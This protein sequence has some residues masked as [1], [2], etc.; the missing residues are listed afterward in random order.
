MA[1]ISDSY[2]RVVIVPVLDAASIITKNTKLR[3]YTNV[4]N[5]P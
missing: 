2:R 5:L 4:M 3:R 1:N